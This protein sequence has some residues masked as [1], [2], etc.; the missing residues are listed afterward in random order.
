MTHRI[1]AAALVCCASLSNA[2]SA[3]MPGGSAN[4]CAAWNGRYSG[5][6][7]EQQSAFAHSQQVTVIIEGRTAYVAIGETAG[8]FDASG[9][10]LRCTSNRV[11]GTLDTGAGGTGKVSVSLKRKAGA[12]YLRLFG[13]NDGDGLK[14]QAAYLPSEEFEIALKRTR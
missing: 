2:A 11:T 7:P 1:L 13:F 12:V 4:T 10:N 8:D 14:N 9:D 6:I 5:E 3:G